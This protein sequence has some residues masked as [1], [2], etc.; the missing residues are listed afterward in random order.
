[1]KPPAKAGM[2]HLCL[3]HAVCFDCHELIHKSTW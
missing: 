3:F 1:M 2:A